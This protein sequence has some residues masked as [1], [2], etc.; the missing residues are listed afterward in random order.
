MLW[1]GK[2]N[3]TGLAAHGVGW[4]DLRYYHMIQMKGGSALGDWS[5]VDKTN[6]ASEE[7]MVL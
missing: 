2:T 4:G 7:Q 6:S 5:S 3:P 1:C